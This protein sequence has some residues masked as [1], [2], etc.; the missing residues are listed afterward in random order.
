MKYQ[1]VN[2]EEPTRSTRSTESIFFSLKRFSSNATKSIYNPFRKRYSEGEL[3][4]LGFT[5]DT[6]SQ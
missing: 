3:F 4:G 2:L 6:D 1:V 5:L